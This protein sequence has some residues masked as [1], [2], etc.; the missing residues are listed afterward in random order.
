MAVNEPRKLPVVDESTRT[1]EHPL[2]HT[3]EGLPG[4]SVA[5]GSIDQLLTWG[6]TNSLWIFPMATSCCGI[7]FMATMASRVDLDRMGSIVRATPRH[8]DVMVIAGTMTVKMASRCKRLWEQMPEPKWCIA[9]GS[10][11]ISGDFYRDLY[12]VVPG[13]DVFLPVDVY[14]PGCPPN[15]EA[16]MHGLLRLQEKVNLARQG[17]FVPRE[18]RPERLAATNPSVPR[19]FD[20]ARPPE[21]TEAQVADALAVSEA[22][23]EEPT[24]EVALPPAEPIAL[25]RDA[26][27]ERIL[28]AHGATP[29]NKQGPALVPVAR[30]VELAAAL[31]AAGYKQLAYIVASHWQAGRGRAGAAAGEPE[32]FE[33]AYGLRTVG[34]NSRVIGW[35]VSVPAVDAEQ[36]PG[37]VPSLVKVF[38]G[39]DW[40]ERE[41]FDLVGVR[42]SGHPDLRRIMLP[43]DWQGHPLRKDYAADTH[44]APWR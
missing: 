40:Q 2:Y 41:Q 10:C 5:L 9:M 44:R 13:V 20:P 32:H 33:V 4:G 6:L 11:A 27:V 16:L 38:A 12:P 17:K 18:L 35:T 25:D 22:P 8:S 28:E 26:T 24:A 43:Q 29:A 36:K 1:Y 30:H 3:I 23:I 39:A 7:E 34:S 31:K 19:I 42:F 37:S 21:T 15:P 14:V